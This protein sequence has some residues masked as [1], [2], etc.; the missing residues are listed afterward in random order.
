MRSAV[1]VIAVV[2]WG[3]AIFVV[4]D[5]FIDDGNAQAVVMIGAC[6]ALGVVVGRAWVQVVPLAA[7]VAVA[8]V[9]VVTWNQQC[10]TCEDDISASGAVILL[11]AFTLIGLVA[12]AAGAGLRRVASR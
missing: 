10:V 4:P 12:T 11:V 9:A 7:G 6:V 3:L 8:V 2:A 5:R 1:N